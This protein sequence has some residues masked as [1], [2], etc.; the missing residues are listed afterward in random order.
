MADRSFRFFP[1]F[2]QFISIFEV[3][4]VYKIVLERIQLVQKAEDKTLGKTLVPGKGT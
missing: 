1:N 3:I 4:G 2:L